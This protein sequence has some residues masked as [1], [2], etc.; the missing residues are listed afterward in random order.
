MVERS[1]H[2]RHGQINVNM[3]N[4]KKKWANRVILLTVRSRTEA[5]KCEASKRPNMCV[6]IDANGVNT[7]V[8]RTALWGGF[9]MSRRKV[10]TH[11]VVKGYSP[12]QEIHRRS[13]WKRQATIFYINFFYISICK[14]VEYL[15]GMSGLKKWNTA[16]SEI[17]RK[18]SCCFYLILVLL[19][20]HMRCHL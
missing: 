1:H 16:T 18:K 20:L 7:G 4:Q 15:Q 5:W 3:L 10:K 13:Q 19:L 17:N 6:T 9:L 8:D 11:W 2:W 12:Y 14:Y